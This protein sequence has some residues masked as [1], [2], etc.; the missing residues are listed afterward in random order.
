M[1][2]DLDWVLLLDSSSSLGE[3]VFNSTRGALADFTTQWLAE[4]KMNSARYLDGGTTRFG[5]IQFA[6][7]VKP[8]F[9]FSAYAG[10][11]SETDDAETELLKRIKSTRWIEGSS[12][13]ALAVTNAKDVLLTPSALTGSRVQR[14]HAWELATS[15][16][17]ATA[18]KAILVITDGLPYSQVQA[19][20]AVADAMAAGVVVHIVGF[21]PLMNEVVR[22][23]LL[24]LVFPAE[25]STA[26]VAT[27]T[28]LRDDHLGGV[29]F[30]ADLTQGSN[31]LANALMEVQN[32]MCNSMHP[33]PPLP[34]L[35]APPTPSPTYALTCSDGKR[36][37]FESDVDCGGPNCLPCAAGKHCE[38]HSDCE[39]VEC[40]ELSACTIIPTAPTAQ[41]T[42]YPTAMPTTSPTP[43]PS[44][45]YAAGTA[46]KRVVV[47]DDYFHGCLIFADC[48]GDGIRQ[49]YE[50]S[51]F[52]VDGT[53]TLTTD[54][55]SSAA[56]QS[57]PT[58][59][60]PSL[61]YQS[62][63]SGCVDAGS[64]AKATVLLSGDSNIVSPLTTLRRALTDAL[65]SD[66]SSV[67]GMS[68]ADKYVK[69]AFPGLDGCD[70][71]RD[72]PF[73][74][75]ASA[76]TAAERA[77]QSRHI[78]VSAQVQNTL[79]VLQQLLL[80]VESNK[81]RQLLRRRLADDAG[82]I[83]GTVR[84]T[85]AVFKALANKIIGNAAATNTTS[86]SITAE[87][88]DLAD[89]AVFQGLLVESYNAFKTENNAD[90]VAV[91]N[92]MDIPADNLGGVATSVARINAQI[93]ALIDGSSGDVFDLQDTDGAKLGLLRGLSLMNH[94]AQVVLTTEMAMLLSDK[95]YSLAN[96]SA[97]TDSSV[98]SLQGKVAEL[99]NPADR[100][101]RAPS[102][103]PT[104]APTPEVNEE[105]PPSVES[106]SEKIKNW[107][108]SQDHSTWYIVGGVVLL[109]VLI[110]LRRCMRA[111]KVPREEQDK[112]AGVPGVSNFVAGMAD[113]RFGAEGPQPLGRTKRGG[114]KAK[115]K[116][117]FSMSKYTTTPGPRS[118][119]PN[120][121]GQAQ[122]APPTPQLYGPGPPLSQV[123]T[124]TQQRPPLDA[125]RRTSCLP[126][127]LAGLKL[128]RKQQEEAARW[129]HQWEQQQRDWQQQQDVQLKE[130]ADQ[131][132]AHLGIRT[133]D[134]A[135]FSVAER[136]GYASAALAPTPTLS[137]GSPTRG[138]AAGGAV[139][140]S[141]LGNELRGMGLKPT[142]A[143]PKARPKWSMMS[144]LLGGPG[145]RERVPPPTTLAPP[146][147]LDGSP[148]RSTN[149]AAA[150]APVRMDSLAATFEKSGP[151]AQQASMRRPVS[152]SDLP[153]TLGHH[154]NRTPAGRSPAATPM[155][156]ETKFELASVQAQ[157]NVTLTQLKAQEDREAAILAELQV[158]KSVATR[159][160]A[161]QMA[162]ARAI[163][164]EIQAESEETALKEAVERARR[165][166][167]EAQQN[168]IALEDAQARKN[169]AAHALQ[170]A[171]ARTVVEEAQAETHM[172][173]LQTAE[174]LAQERARSRVNA[175]EETRRR[176]ATAQVP[177]VRVRGT[178]PQSRARH[179][180]V[181]RFDHLNNT[182]APSPV[183]THVGTTISM[184]QTSASDQS[185]DSARQPTR[186]SVGVQD[187]IL[188]MAAEINDLEMAEINSEL[189]MLRAEE[190]GRGR[191]E[192][193][194]PSADR[195]VRV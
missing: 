34:K 70:F 146:A 74:L 69:L 156:L 150:R 6:T 96:F 173:T 24:E 67:S 120:R 136:Q 79:T 117:G 97:A 33:L 29:F 18:R 140:S 22:S 78:A 151:Q 46:T 172:R 35:E 144:M 53:C 116:R 145:R 177:G 104:S 109:L 130:E 171:Q 92:K 170:L 119:Y 87:P 103:A 63:A 94:M 8:E 90:V 21:G 12:S 17:N 13:T 68:D 57:C 65:E 102:A 28:N 32:A 66:S 113:G 128:N 166:E 127:P 40:D 154:A 186:Y 89:T 105:T 59:F 9:D 73:A 158:A 49:A 19:A 192:D 55:M 126:L 41:P 98:S 193:R 137:A 135:A 174:K 48:N 25:T 134:A 2:R 16:G 42:P 138:G 83:V 99:P 111:K 11:D 188:D 43:R 159:A 30:S 84:G 88:V 163:V 20:T 133:A 124:P 26:D 4:R 54:S 110:M 56:F 142:G 114:V 39:S 37:G 167:V 121:G 178:S 5:L 183:P 181:S 123:R 165:L 190:F 195:S 80:K 115:A 108:T 52:T 62:G 162:K 180:A 155:S 169:A 61:S 131:Q 100:V 112:Q 60:H 147:W 160:D 81:R 189:S 141:N 107:I 50:P 157:R 152:L 179:F 95:N 129:Q 75:H 76:A 51:C 149:D 187:Q 14:T 125:N 182:T 93:S 45:Y 58:V 64:G 7:E 168:A 153:V 106:T 175:E 148:G 91:A 132:A 71:D 72:D 15:T 44:A 85:G 38:L 77:T 10:A 101:T 82:M 47:F 191:S 194:P 164:G 118:S 1:E 139:A 161:F 86:T 31:G 184:V 185:Y 176:V 23:K 122:A 3:S 27:N 36:D 143:Q